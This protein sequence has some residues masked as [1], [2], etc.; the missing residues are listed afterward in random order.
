MLTLHPEASSVVSLNCRKKRRV[1]AF[2]LIGSADNP[3][4]EEAQPFLKQL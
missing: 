3:R 2:E 4:L 1:V